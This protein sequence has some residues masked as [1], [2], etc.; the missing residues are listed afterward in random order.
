[1][2]KKILLF[3]DDEQLIE[4]LNLILKIKGYQ[5][6]HRPNCNNVIEVI[7]EELPDLILMD[8]RIPDM[9]GVEATKLIKSDDFTKN[10]P[11][12][13]V[14]ADIHTKEKATLSGADGYIVKPFE[15][16]DFEEAI[17]KHLNNK[18]QR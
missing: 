5:V 12:I 9:G 16:N 7:Y 17:H 8:L 4:L 2:A 3:E 18:R 6:E 13:I 1:M 15:I 14:S 10:I 11:V